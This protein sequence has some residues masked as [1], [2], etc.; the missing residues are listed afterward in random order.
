MTKKVV[1]TK[2]MGRKRMTNDPCSI[3]DKH[4]MALKT[5]NPRQGKFKIRWTRPYLIKEVYNNGSV[6]VITFQDQKLGRISMSKIKPYYEP[7]MAKAY[8]LQTLGTDNLEKEI[9]EGKKMNEEE[10]RGHLEIKD[11]NVTSTTN[12]E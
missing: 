2:N 10:A 9:E 8:V 7:D 12:K 3:L 6:D 1:R 11:Q 5:K 4:F